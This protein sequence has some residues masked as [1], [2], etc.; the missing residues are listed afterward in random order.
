MSEQ[1]KECC[2]CLEHLNEDQLFNSKKRLC[3][4]AT[5][6]YS[7]FFDLSN[8][9]YKCP[10]C[11]TNLDVVIIDAMDGIMKSGSAAL[12]PDKNVSDVIHSI[13][14]KYL[15]AHVSSTFTKKENID[16]VFAFISFAQRFKLKVDAVITLVQVATCF[17]DANTMHFKKLLEF[18]IDNQIKGCYGFLHP[19]AQ[20]IWDSM[21]VL[22]GLLKND[23]IYDISSKI[24][25]Y[26]IYYC[27]KQLVAPQFTSYYN[28]AVHPDITILEA[29]SKTI[30]VL[31]DHH[32]E[33]TPQLLSIF[34]DVLKKNFHKS[35]LYCNSD[36]FISPMLS[37]LY[38]CMVLSTKNTIISEDA[39]KVFHEKG[40]VF[41]LL[42]WFGMISSAGKG[43]EQSSSW[44]MKIFGAVFADS[45]FSLP[46]IDANR[47]SYQVISAVSDPLN[48][49]P[50][51]SMVFEATGMIYKFAEKNKTALLTALFSSGFG[52]HV[53][54]AL[55]MF[56]KRFPNVYRN[57]RLFHRLHNFL[58]IF[59][60]FDFTLELRKK[61]NCDYKTFL[62]QNN[63]L[64]LALKANNF[65]AQCLS[66]LHDFI[67]ISN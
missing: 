15:D 7:C 67:V 62:D 53:V 5:T 50:I 36:L 31:L 2:V 56:F 55:S 41:D 39:G 48:E 24:F 12:F 23:D 52:T 9:D 10:V 46:T 35:S 64:L 22:L 29:L 32:V 27:K 57:A 58:N 42:I 14:I 11:R 43:N 66:E 65:C 63:E 25:K 37:A 18:V 17:P 1:M 30:I 44:L 6:C 28:L 4:S 16:T 21:T 49:G 51:P 47:L 60:E 61:L 33:P 20:F 26:I 40:T 34:I 54:Y 13:C 19:N 8:H 59:K 3:C 38:R 45:R